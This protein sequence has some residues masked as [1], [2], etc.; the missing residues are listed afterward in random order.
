MAK[1]GHELSELL[2]V[3]ME[4]SWVGGYGAD[5]HLFLPRIDVAPFVPGPHP[6]PQTRAQ[7]RTLVVLSRARCT[8]TQFLKWESPPRH[9]SF[10]SL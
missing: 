6:M 5:F 3:G 4:Q 9:L 10:W 1:N 8:K 2:R 7:A